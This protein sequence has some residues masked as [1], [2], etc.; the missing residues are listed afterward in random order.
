MILAKWAETT[1]RATVRSEGRSWRRV[2]EIST[3][4]TRPGVSLGVYW[5]TRADG[6]SWR[7]LGSDYLSV[8]INTTL[9]WGAMH[10]WYDGPHCHFSIGPIHFAWTN[11]DCRRCAEGT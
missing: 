6:G 1:E 11:W 2:L 3:W 9:K 10:A 7:T 4:L 8:S 5:Q